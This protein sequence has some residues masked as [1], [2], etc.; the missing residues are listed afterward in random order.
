MSYASGTPLPQFELKTIAKGIRSSFLSRIEGSFNR[1][2][3]DNDEAVSSQAQICRTVASMEIGASIDLLKPIN[4]LSSTGRKNS[5]Q[6]QYKSYTSC[7]DDENQELF[8]SYS[9][10]KGVSVSRKVRVF[11][12]QQQLKESAAAN[13]GTLVM[14]WM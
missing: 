8:Y 4:E 11:Q 1:R 7:N 10:Q 12:R 9:C 14:D 6:D 13:E 5:Y 2:R 3:S